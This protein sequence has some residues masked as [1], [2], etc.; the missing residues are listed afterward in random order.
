MSYQPPY[1]ISSFMLDCVSDIMKSIGHLLGR[2]DLE[3]Q[4]ALRRSNQIR[5]IHSSLAIENNI[6]TESQINDIQKGKL[7][8]GPKKD[9]TE[10]KNA[11]RV[12]ERILDINPYDVNELLRIHGMM[13]ESLAD[14]AGRFRQGQVGVF[15]GD[16]PIFLAPPADRVPVLID[17]LFD[18]LNHTNENFLIKSCVFHYEL[19]FIHPFSDGNGR[20][21]RLFQ[22]CLLADK[23]PVF[24]YLPI[25]SIIKERQEAYYQAIADSNRMGESTLFVEFMLDAIRETTRR[26]LGQTSVATNIDDPY[27]RK[28]LGLM[29]PNVAYS[30]KELLDLLGNKSLVNFKSKYLVPALKANLIEMTL[31]D[32]PTSKNQRYIIRHE[33]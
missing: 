27:V 22:T 33:S 16:Q 17:D 24:A 29:K 32:T 25:E 2:G 4:P 19:E 30:A 12:Y 18:Y 26:I 9:I 13:M 7:V 21:G 15:D 28:L 14:D 10:A 5:S 3:R 1:R 31:P 8:Y 23:E 11:I 6:L 20:M